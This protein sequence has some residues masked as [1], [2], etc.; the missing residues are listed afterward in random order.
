MACDVP[1][2]AGVV[3]GGCATGGLGRG[4]DGKRPGG[5]ALSGDFGLTGAVPAEVGRLSALRELHLSHN[6]LTSLPA[7]IGQLTALTKL[8]LGYNQL[9]SLPAEVGQL[10]SLT[11]LEPR[12]QSADELCRRRSGSSSRWRGCTSTAIG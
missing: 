12:R 1:C 5:E 8:D 7:E 4:D 2:T 10:T 3:A 11:V 9:T 6:Q